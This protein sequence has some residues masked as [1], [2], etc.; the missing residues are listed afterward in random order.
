M[1]IFVLNP[2]KTSKINKI[3]FLTLAITKGEFNVKVMIGK[4]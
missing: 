1:C 2:P 4:N 3:V